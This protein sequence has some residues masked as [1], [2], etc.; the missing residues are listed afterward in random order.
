MNIFH[1][2]SWYPS[3]DA[4]ISGI[5]TK[6]QI[7]ILSKYYSA[8]N[9]GISLWGQKTEANLLW[10]KD[11]LKNVLKIIKGLNQ[12]PS[13][14]TL[15]PNLI[16]YYAPAFTWTEKFLHG[17]ISGILR[18]NE[19][20]LNIFSQ[21]TGKV[22]LI[23]AHV[24]FP[25]GLIAQH[26]SYKYRIPYIIT[27]QMSPFPFESFKS[28]GKPMNKVL[29]PIQKADAII[30]IS[31][32]AAQDIKQMT[33]VQSIVIPNLVDETVFKPLSEANS[34]KSNQPF[35]FFTLGRMVQQK[36]ISTLIHAIA[37]LK[38]DNIRFRIGGDGEYLKEY[39][40][41][42][43]TLAIKDHRIVWLG[44]LKREEA[45][46]EF[47]NCHAFVLPSIHESMGVVYAEALA[48]GKPIIATYCGGPEFIVN[49]HNGLL[50]EVNAPQQL[51]QAMNYLVRNIH[52][53]SAAEIRADFMARFSSGVI[54]KKIY[55]LY[56]SLI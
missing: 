29:S 54:T 2:P 13:Q 22:S 46:M 4:P 17:N 19:Q 50:V 34:F 48:C 18:A 28:R 51:S 5:F 1:I 35:T 26:L 38:S 12:H 55:T 11:H 56:E 30:A 23:H 7:I 14:T 39:K 36:G 37:L 10:T 21:N 16:E 27:E 52:K 45:A 8:S 20:N 25:A 24:S 53:Y 33:N 47:A 32:S 15:A 43:D 6:E 31:P 44:E 42:A 40:Q 9:F 49:K 3:A 41:L